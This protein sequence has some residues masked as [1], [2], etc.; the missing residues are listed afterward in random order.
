MVDPVCNL[1]SLPGSDFD[2]A[3]DS[4]DSYFRPPKGARVDAARKWTEKER[5]LLV[6]GIQK[7]GIGHFRDISE[8]FLPSWVS[9][10]RLGEG[11]SKCKYNFCSIHSTSDHP[12]ISTG[13]TTRV[14][15]TFASRQ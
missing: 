3:R 12:L 6:K 11:S 2:S 15:T 14:V 1:L 13:T 9:S 8:D 4:I 5:E 10:G 7:Y